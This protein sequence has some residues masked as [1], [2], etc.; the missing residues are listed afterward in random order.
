[1]SDGGTMGGASYQKPPQIRI[2]LVVT[3]DRK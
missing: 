2:R 3:N 1:M